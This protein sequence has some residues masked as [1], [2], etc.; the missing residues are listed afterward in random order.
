MAP[1]DP[2]ISRDFHFILSFHF[3]ILKLNPG[4]ISVNL[5]DHYCPIEYL[6]LANRKNVT[7][8]YI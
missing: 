2:P 6:V 8:K 7:E 4:E 5:I 1:P 3:V